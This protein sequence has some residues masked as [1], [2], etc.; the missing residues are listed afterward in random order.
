MTNL[1]LLLATLAIATALGMLNS[2]IANLRQDISI[3]LQHQDALLLDRLSEPTEHPSQKSR[4][5]S[6]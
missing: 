5:R 2:S 1:P 3:A 4:L 6:I